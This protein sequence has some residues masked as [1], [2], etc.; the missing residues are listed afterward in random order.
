[1]STRKIRYKLPPLCVTFSLA[2][3]MVAC[4]TV[5]PD[6]EQPSLKAIEA[7]QTE[8]FANSSAISGG[9]TKKAL[10]QSSVWYQL[11]DPD[12]NRLLKLMEDNTDVQIAYK[13]LLVA[14]NLDRD[15]KLDSWPQPDTQF[16]AVEKRDSESK[17]FPAEKDGG[18]YQDYNLT[19]SITWE[20]DWIG[21]L[22]RSRESADANVMSLQAQ[23][24][25]IRLLTQA[26]IVRQ[27]CLLRGVQAQLL[28]TRGNA[29]RQKDTW[30]LTQSRL[31]A[32]VATPV[33]VARAKSQYYA[34]LSSVPP[35]ES[36]QK[37]ALHRLS[38]LTGQ[39]ARATYQD[40]IKPK[41]MPLLPLVSE[42]SLNPNNVLKKR[43]DVQAAEAN[44]RRAVADIGVKQALWFPKI[45]LLGDL[46]LASENLNDLSE[47]ASVFNLFG[48]R[49]SWAILGFTRLDVIA[50][51]AELNAD[52][53]Y[54]EYKQ[55]VLLALEEVENALV[56]YES[57]QSVTQYLEQ[58]A[59]AAKQA[60]E[61]AQQRY[62][63]GVINFIEVLDVER[64]QLEIENELAGAKTQ[65]A[66]AMVNLYLSLAED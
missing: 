53:A 17:S 45:T 7:Y 43:P 28:A 61:L 40:L 42:I 29:A 10:P 26:E 24:N 59:T 56:A 64:R 14:K 30:S 41:K 49:I 31:D 47:G 48:V 39:S 32:G 50:S 33:D 65:A 38:V 62:E 25:E 13:R 55:K 51:R 60:T 22:K 4:M 23:L 58:S 44:L 19:E 20:L 37:Q 46:G 5:G 18:A 54:K 52:I 27:Y 8:G 12:L 36:Q 1:M 3:N 63:G 11:K 2:F 16:T 34:T 35:L 66:L 15:T 9:E 6:F 57:T 21:R